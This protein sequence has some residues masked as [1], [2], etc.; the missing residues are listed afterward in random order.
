MD[1]HTALRTILE[2]SPGLK[3][4]ILVDEVHQKIG[5]SRS[6]IYE[7]LSSLEISDEIYRE[8]GRYWWGKPEVFSKKELTML[9]HSKK[10]IPALEAL[11]FEDSLGWLSEWHESKYTFK[12][13]NEGLKIKQY[14]E[15]H[16]KAP[17]YNDVYTLL[18]AHRHLNDSIILDHEEGRVSKEVFDKVI[19]CVEAINAHRLTEAEK[20]QTDEITNK[21]LT[22]YSKLA[23]AIRLLEKKIE[24]GRPLKGKCQLCA[25]L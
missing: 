17:E 25:E 14:A 20:K 7:Y 6:T 18:L 4:K 23:E 15:E 13:E 5:L 8:R 21:K 11:L 24:H 19:R 9:E 3:A 2:K 1:F 16:L 10:L 12:I 22:S